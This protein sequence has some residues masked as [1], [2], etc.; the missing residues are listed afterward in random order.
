MSCAHFFFFLNKKYCSLVQLFEKK[1][2]I[3]VSERVESYTAE[4]ERFRII[5]V[6]HKSVSSGFFCVCCAYCTCTT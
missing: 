1:M 5:M 6:L 4:E 2:D 3:K